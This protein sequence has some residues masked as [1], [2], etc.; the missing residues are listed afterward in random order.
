MRF[1]P[2]TEEDLPA[3]NRLSPKPLSPGAVRFFARSG[4]S[5]LA[6][7]EGEARGF[8]LAQAVWQGEGVLLWVSRLEAQDETALRGLLRALLKSGQDAGVHRVALGLSP[9][10]E[11]LKA[12]LEEEGF[13]F[14]LLAEKTLRPD[15]LG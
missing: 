11:G 6:E 2:F 8:I 5:F 1:R 12:L 15:P 9:E 14:R 3:L 4:H 7:E 13:G 10:D